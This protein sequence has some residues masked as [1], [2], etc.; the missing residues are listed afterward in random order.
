MDKVDALLEE[1][2]KVYGDPVE[3]H[4]KIA[5]VWSGIIG[6]NI[7][8]NEVPLMMIGL[9]LVRAQQSPEY[10]DSYDDIEGYTRIAKMF[11]E[12]KQPSSDR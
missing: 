6:Y 8:P 4:V 7:Q 1:R 2:G 10:P 12:L 11:P 9:K 5:Q 3:T